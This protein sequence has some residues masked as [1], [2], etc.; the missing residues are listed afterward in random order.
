MPA[1]QELRRP[2]LHDANHDFELGSPS[3]RAA[4][5]TPAVAG[6]C[7]I[8]HGQRLLPPRRTTR[9]ENF[10]EKKHLSRSN[11][12]SGNTASTSDVHAPAAVTNLL[13]LN[14]TSTA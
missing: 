14:V 6:K 9:A 1:R 5:P 12:A 7:A 13:V 2:L 3:K 8:I 11:I 10:D 4:K